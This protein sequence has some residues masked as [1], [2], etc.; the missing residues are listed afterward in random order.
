MATQ[1]QTEAA[2]ATMY[3]VA[4]KA[5]IGEDAMRK[6][7]DAALAVPVDPS[8]YSDE[9]VERAYIAFRD[10][11]SD[12]NMAAMR[13]ALAA[14]GVQ[15]DLLVTALRDTLFQRDA[16]IAAL[17]AQLNTIET[18]AQTCCAREK[19]EAAQRIA[20]LEAQ[21]SRCPHGNRQPCS[22]CEQL[23]QRAESKPA[24][25]EVSVGE[26][27]FIIDWFSGAGLCV[28]TSMSAR[29]FAEAFLAQR[30]CG[31][32]PKAAAAVDDFD[33]DCVESMKSNARTM[34][35]EITRLRERNR[36]LE[37]MIVAPEDPAAYSDTPASLYINGAPP[38]NEQLAGTVRGG[39][40]LITDERREVALA[41][42]VRRA[43]ASVPAAPADGREVSDAGVLEWSDKDV[44]LVQRSL[45]MHQV[46]FDN[47][48]HGLAAVQP[49]LRAAY[50]AGRERGIIQARRFA[51]PTP[52]PVAAP[53][54]TVEELVK[55][56]RSG[57]EAPG[58]RWY[59]ALDELVSRLERLEGEAGR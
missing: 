52:A 40:A 29:K 23:S 54:R 58:E 43:A 14:A 24:G 38:T 19:R 53:K 28:P 6:I 39:F 1:K 4:P 7:I 36:E 55:D 33:R 9:Q 17:E 37:A 31:S 15:P 44:R 32:A 51:Q 3:D 13:A 41:E 22:T 16:R 34:R 5:D 26:V 21:L 30:A 27:G 8:A 46:Y 35:A 49:K 45:I 48:K 42:L 11:E 10:H 2:L 25:G 12:S 59:G 47:L 20:D 18:E 57:F 56:V 50:E